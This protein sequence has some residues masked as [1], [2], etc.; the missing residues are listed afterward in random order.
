MEIAA[1]NPG[2]VAGSLEQLSTNAMGKEHPGECSSYARN[3]MVMHLT[4]DST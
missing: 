1:G 2:D 4:N 3:A